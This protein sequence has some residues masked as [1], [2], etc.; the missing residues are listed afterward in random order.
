[1]SRTPNRGP[2]PRIAIAAFALVAL[3]ACATGARSGAGAR[4]APRLPE[5]R[6]F[7]I[8]RHATPLPDGA[9]RI[10]PV[11]ADTLWRDTLY[12][13]FEPATDES[14][15]Y[16]FSGE[17]DFYAQPG[18]TLG[19]FWQMERGGANAGGLTAQFGPD[20]TFPQPQPWGVVGIGSVTYDRTP[21]S[22]RF[23]FFYAIP[24]NALQPV[25]AGRRYTLS[26]L[27]LGA[28]HPQLSGCDRP[29]CIE[30]RTASMSYRPESTVVIRTGDRRVT[31]GDAATSCAE[32]IPAWRPRG[33][34]KPSPTGAGTPR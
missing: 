4:V 2:N 11:C 3:A 18:D 5:N 27:L 12:L 24:K 34:A 9:W 29:V 21:Q 17:V 13:A 8:P 14:T 26:R 25:R 19:S 22:A 33:L 30:W 32:R 7:L 6:L 23:R 31:R 20:S 16:G 28:R 1:M 10:P 15:F